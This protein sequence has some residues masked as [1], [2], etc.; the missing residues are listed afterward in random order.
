MT[1]LGALTIAAIVLAGCAG[2]ETSPRSSPNT[3][4]DR[5]SI[6]AAAGVTDTTVV[7]VPALSSGSTISTVGLDDVYFGMTL[8]EAQDASASGFIVAGS[9]ASA[10]FS[11]TP[12]AG[13]EGITFTFV[14]GR[15]ERVDVTA[16]PIATR[17]GA[18]VGSTEAEV[19]TLYGDR[20]T[21]VTRDDGKPGNQ[22]VFVPRDAEDAA[23][24]LVFRTDGTTVT[25]YHAGRL[26]VAERQPPC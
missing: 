1:R 26:P 13:P 14:D 2:D 17:S 25:D 11:A 23:F 15:V 20:L 16:P 4:T 9:E 12:D 10:C 24:R 5:P 21:Q 3:T 8:T 7:R 6:D 19:R 18:R 22:L